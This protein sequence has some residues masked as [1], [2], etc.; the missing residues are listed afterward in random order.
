MSV[1]RQQELGIEIGRDYPQ[2]IVDHIVQ[3]EQALA[4]YQGAS[5]R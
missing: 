2:P 1:A 4:L 5:Q 3:R